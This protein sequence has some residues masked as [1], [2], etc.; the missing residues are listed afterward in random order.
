[1]PQTAGPPS[2]ASRESADRL[3]AIA[4]CVGF[5]GAV[6][7]LVDCEIGPKTRGELSD[8]LAEID[9]SLRHRDPRL[10]EA[11]LIQLFA[12]TKTSASDSAED[13]ATIYAAHLGGLPTW[14]VI[15][16]IREI[17]Q[18]RGES[19]TFAPAAPE[20]HKRAE[21]ALMGIWHERKKLTDVLDAAAAAD[22]PRYVSEDEAARRRRHVAEMV[23][24]F[25]G[26]GM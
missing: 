8:R 21:R 10:L 12:V 15:D 23:A 19:A 6:P 9:A 11:A 13:L 7:R 25:A 4:N 3:A 24:G 22:P 5:F 17:A 26:R 20:I 16:A 1:M 14:A 2:A 18:G